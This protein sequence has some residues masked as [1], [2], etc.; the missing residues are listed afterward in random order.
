MT[1]IEKKL[2]KHGGSYAIDLPKDFLK[3]RSGK[4]IVKYDNNKLLILPQET[5]DNIES[6]PEFKSFVK[7]LVN[8]SLKHPGKLKDLTQVWD[9]E[10]DKLLKGVTVDDDE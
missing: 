3:S 2:F 4:V 10:W 7:A 6:E 1:I 8:D 9:K 5:A